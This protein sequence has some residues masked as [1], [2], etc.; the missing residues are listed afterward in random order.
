MQRLVLMAEVIKQR[1]VHA[2]DHSVRN[3]KEQHL[4]NGDDLDDDDEI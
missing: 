2:T 4:D 3:C 1:R